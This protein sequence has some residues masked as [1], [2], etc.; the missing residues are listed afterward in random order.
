MK[1]YLYPTIRMKN[2]WI[3]RTIGEV[4]DNIGNEYK[5]MQLFE[6]M[7][8]VYGEDIK[9]FIYALTRND[10]L[11]S[12]EIF[13]N[14]MVG[15]LEDLYY[16]RDND[17]MKAWLFAIAKAE[18]KRYYAEKQNKNTYEHFLF[19]ETELECYSYL[20]DF[21]ESIEDKEY[22]QV[23]IECLKGAEKQLC[24]LYY[25]YGLTLKEIASILDLNYNTVRSM[26]FR[27]MAKLRK[28]LIEFERS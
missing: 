26:H 23:L 24:V 12:E 20:F 25:Y 5:K 27:G 17:K 22:I 2:R 4:M 28:R 6:K 19:V 1:I 3:Y 11:A 16:L 9:R 18:S 21:T 14:A 15:A 10:P 13:Q 8:S 7:C